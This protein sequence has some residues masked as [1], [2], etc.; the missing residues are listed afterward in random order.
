MRSPV[1]KPVAAAGALLALAA[2]LA[3]LP[4]WSQGPRSRE[5]VLAEIRSEMRRLEGELEQARRRRT[6]LED[7]LES[8]RLELALQGKRLEEAVAARE[9]AG[10]RV[11]QS[12][13][14]VEALAAAVAQARDLLSRRLS[15][16]YRLG[17]H[18]QLRLLLSID[19]DDDLLP[20]V[21]MLRFLVRR[22]ARV[23]ERYTEAREHLEAE[24][25]V[26]LERQ[27]ESERWAREE[28]GR[29]DE[30]AGIERRLSRLLVQAEEERRRLAVAAEDLERRERR[31]TELM[32]SLERLSGDEALAGG[33]P[34][35]E[36]RG[37]LDW[38]ADGRVTAR[39]G[40][41]L[42]PRYGTRTPHNG[43]ELG[44]EPGSR[45]RAVFPGKVLFAAPL[46]GYGPTVVMLHPGRGFTL[47]AGLDRLLVASE[48]VVSLGD[49]VGVA[50]RTLYFEIRIDNRPRDPLDWL[51]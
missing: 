1:S 40:P 6:G 2:L 7:R 12:R 36:Y 39:F 29:R 48:D 28:T 4:L 31:L 50:G 9:L 14:D 18:G 32:V 11:A 25:R 17:R 45:V 37:V 46:S 19:P 15:S 42:D 49:P 44:V 33:T 47:Y 16:L 38:P 27:R 51:R 3:A 26:L 34:I 5:A 8:T 22:D 21:R 43:I 13:E 41:R 23:V 10:E 24:R 20:A 35:Q 30:L